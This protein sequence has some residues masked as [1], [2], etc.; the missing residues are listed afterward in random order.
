VD[1]S[2]G[3]YEIYY[4]KSTD[5][6]ARWTTKRLTWSYPGSWD[7]AIAVDPN[8][9]IH[10][11]WYDNNSGDTDIFY[12]RSTDGG[13]S[14]ITKRLTWNSGSWHPAITTDSNSHIHVVWEDSTPGNDEIYYDKSTD[15]GA[16][17]I[18]KR[19]TLNSGS[20]RHPSI[21]AGSNNH[22]HVVW[23]DSTPG[24]DEIYY[25]K[26]TDGGTSWSQK[27][28]T[29]NSSDSE[30]T[31]IAVD[32]NNHIHVVW[33]NEP[34]VV[35]Y[36]IYYK[37]STDGGTSWSSKRLTWNSAPSQYPSIAVGPNNNIH[38]VWEDPGPGNWEIFYKKG[39][40]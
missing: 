37:R 39:I 1:N 18:T 23:E 8:N 7:P 20:S 4:K 9:H 16:S 15:G 3:A 10:V 22:I 26:S 27:R 30:K 19:L 11:V 33:Q 28:L 36:E 38:V 32:S 13:A 21:S 35:D 40:Q 24:N 2:S 14:W 34:T 5:G 31:A 25:D 12:K 29:W 6:G 17:W